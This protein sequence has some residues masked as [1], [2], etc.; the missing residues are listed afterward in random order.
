MNFYQL[1]PHGNTYTPHLS[2]CRHFRTFAFISPHAA[3]LTRPVTTW[4][5]LLLLLLPQPATRPAPPAPVACSAAR[6]PPSCPCWAPRAVDV[7]LPV[8]PAPTSTTTHA[9]AVSSDTAPLWVQHLAHVRAHSMKPLPWLEFHHHVQQNLPLQSA[10]SSR[11][12]FHIKA[13]QRISE[14]SLEFF[15]EFSTASTRTL[16]LS[17]LLWQ[18]IWT[19]SVDKLERL[20]IFVAKYFMGSCHTIS[21]P[22]MRVCCKIKHRPFPKKSRSWKSSIYFQNF[23]EIVAFSWIMYSGPIT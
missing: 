21:A 8:R 17:K 22:D 18:I 5:G 13:R 20:I 7:W 19:F 9:A 2:S 4:Q 11:R 16:F 1:R 14:N 10:T 15:E 6:A 23:I 3:T 12:G